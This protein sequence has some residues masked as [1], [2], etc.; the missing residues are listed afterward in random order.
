MEQ[1]EVNT[2]TR[3][4]FRDIT[5]QVQE[6]IRRSGVRE[7]ICYLFCP[8]TTA[9]LTVNENYDPTVRQDL[10]MVLDQIAP[11]QFPYRHTEGN[12]DAHVKTSLVGSHLALFI[13]EGRLVLG[14]WQGVFLAEFDGPRRRK[15]LVK[16]IPG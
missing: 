12:A 13:S 16:V 8:H 4:E 5:A 3:K 10:G 7:G 9:G 1:I 15:V 6:V 14:T 2:Q 11:D